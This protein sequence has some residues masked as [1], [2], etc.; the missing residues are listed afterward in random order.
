M[1]DK[2]RDLQALSYQSRQFNHASHSIEKAVWAFLTRPD[3]VIRMETAFA[4]YQGA[5]GRQREE[6]FDLIGEVLD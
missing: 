6:L 4:T 2:T 5:H 3:N 1:L